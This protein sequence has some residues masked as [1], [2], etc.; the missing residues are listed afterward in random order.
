MLGPLCLRRQDGTRQAERARHQERRG[1]GEQEQHAEPQPAPADRRRH[2]PHRAVEE[3]EHGQQ[4]HRQRPQQQAAHGCEVAQRHARSPTQHRPQSRRGGQQDPHDHGAFDHDVDENPRARPAEHRGQARH[5]H[6]GRRHRFPPPA[7]RDP[8]H[9][10]AH[11]DGRRRHQH[12]DHEDEPLGAG[13]G[14]VDVDRVLTRHRDDHD[15]ERHTHRERGQRRRRPG[16]H[17]THQRAGPQHRGQ[18]AA[19]EPLFCSRAQVGVAGTGD[20][21]R[22]HLTTPPSSPTVFRTGAL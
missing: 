4:H 16:P 22:P 7:M 11:R 17:P 9:H 2:G 10:P 15:R 13:R 8:R 3:H 5:G 6:R 1:D 21:D 14:A 18:T 12:H 19:Q 20:H